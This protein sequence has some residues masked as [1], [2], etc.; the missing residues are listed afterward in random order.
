[1]I[2]AQVVYVACIDEID[3]DVLSQPVGQHLDELV[4]IK[5]PRAYSGHTDSAPIRQ[6]VESLRGTFSKQFRKANL[7]TPLEQILKEHF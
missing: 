6:F 2:H 1:M 5:M 4:L 3:R 7:T